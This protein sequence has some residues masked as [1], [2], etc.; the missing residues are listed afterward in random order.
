[1]NLTAYF[2]WISKVLWVLKLFYTFIRM[3]QGKNENL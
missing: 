3:A 2:Y 1:M